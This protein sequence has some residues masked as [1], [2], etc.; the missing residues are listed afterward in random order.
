MI[1][2]LVS[3]FAATSLSVPSIS[4]S[5]RKRRHSVGL[6]HLGDGNGAL[7]QQHEIERQ[8]LLLCQ[9]C[10]AR[11]FGLWSGRY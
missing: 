1:H 4:R 9:S 6:E 5:P 3:G 2:L 10:S 8:P 11:R 7:V